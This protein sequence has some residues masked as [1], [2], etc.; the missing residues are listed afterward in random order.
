MEERGWRGADETQVPAGISPLIDPGRK[1]KTTS[2]RI[3]VSRGGPTAG[4][5]D[6]SRTD[7]GRTLGLSG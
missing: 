6:F 5:V 7:P 1:K 3:F 2:A 4:L